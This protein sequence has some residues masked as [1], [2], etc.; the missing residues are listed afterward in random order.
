MA[1]KVNTSAKS[2]TK[3]STT[4]KGLDDFLEKSSAAPGEVINSLQVQEQ[5][6]A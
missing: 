2:S 6:D 5:L 4:F 1:P 3:S